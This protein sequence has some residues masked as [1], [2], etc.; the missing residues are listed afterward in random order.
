MPFAVTIMA[1]VGL[2]TQSS[3]K[4]LLDAWSEFGPDLLSNDPEERNES[5]KLS[6]E[7]GLVKRDPDAIPLLAL[8]SLLPAGAA[9]CENLNKWAPE[10]KISI[11]SCAI[12]TLSR[13]ALLVVKDGEKWGNP[14]IS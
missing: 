12:T 5:I 10:L 13:A 3:A 6:V 2:K 4:R 9:T 7:S 14:V 8:L 11:L 1:K